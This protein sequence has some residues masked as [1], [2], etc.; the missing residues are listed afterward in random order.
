MGR[1][2]EFMKIEIEGDDHEGVGQ[3]S[4]NNFDVGRGCH[5]DLTDVRR[6]VAR[7]SQ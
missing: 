2:E 5:S 3:G 7:F 1:G 4:A 6:R